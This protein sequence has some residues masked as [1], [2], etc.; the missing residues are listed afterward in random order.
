MH[1][2]AS[3]ISELNEFLPLIQKSPWSGAYENLNLRP[4]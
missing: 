3:V 4:F 2:D 1:V